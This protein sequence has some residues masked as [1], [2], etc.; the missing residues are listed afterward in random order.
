MNPRAMV[1]VAYF[2][3]QTS[4]AVL[5]LEFKFRTIDLF[6]LTAIFAAIAGSF[7]VEE[8]YFRQLLWLA[9]V[10]SCATIT[11]GFFPRAKRLMVPAAIGGFV[12]GIAFLAIC[13]L[14]RERLFFENN[15]YV[16][17]PNTVSNLSSEIAIGFE[18]I[19]FLLVSIPLGAALGPL[20]ALRFRDEPIGET[21][22]KRFWLSVILG[23]A[24]LLLALFSVYER[25]LWSNRDWKLLLMIVV[26]FFIFHSI[27]WFRRL[28]LAERRELANENKLV[29][30]CED[31]ESASTLTS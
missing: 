26:A 9:L 13:L 31:I 11:V 12:G 23:G 22:L 16:F 10:G 28:E 27:N 20:I 4:E 18:M 3:H 2:I 1:F 19:A 8:F 29:G 17:A 30:D 7:R 21:F 6:V 24:A 15:F 5:N 14:F 25:T